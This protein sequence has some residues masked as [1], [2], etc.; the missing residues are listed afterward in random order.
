MTDKNK[1][2]LSARLQYHFDNFM[3][4]GTL[5]IISGLGL[6]S[7]LLISIAGIVISLGGQLL[8]PAG[9][10]QGLS[11]GEA[12][13]ESLMRT[14]D[15]GTMGGDEG[16]GYRFAM[17][18]VTI[19]GILI[20]SALIGVV[21]AGVESKLAELRKG[22]SNVLENG[23]IL[24]LGWSAQIF[25]ILSELIEANLNQPNTHIVILADR[26]KVEMEDEIR[27]RIQMRGRTRIICRSGQPID[28]DDIQISSPHTARSRPCW[29]SSTTQTA[30]LILTISSLRCRTPITWRSST[31]SVAVTASSLC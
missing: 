1:A 3:S 28:L 13:W 23:H 15:A 18:A 31:F 21:S 16:W 19:G 7:L 30:V 10:D 25:T 12:A 4:R 5:A 22:R 2:P 26:D 27:S 6:L 20:V 11:F 24:I 8:A 9:S 29:R 17:L 14:L